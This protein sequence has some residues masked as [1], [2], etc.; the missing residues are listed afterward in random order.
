MSRFNRRQ[1]LAVAGI[2]G[3]GA[4]LTAIA[5]KAPLATDIAPAQPARQP[6]GYQ[7]SEHIRKYYRT[8]R[9]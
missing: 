1:F 8:A 9:V 3:A 6:R 4:A 5:G 7:V 2:G